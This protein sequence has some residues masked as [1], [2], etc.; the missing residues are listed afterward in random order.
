MADTF[1][2]GLRAKSARASAVS[3]GVEPPGGL[4]K[5]RNCATVEGECMHATSMFASVR[6]LRSELLW[7]ALGEFNRTGDDAPVAETTMLSFIIA[8]IFSPK[9]LPEI[10]PVL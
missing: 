9:E 1:C 4:V 5:V 3:C 8:A 2:P 10:I 6:V 7:S